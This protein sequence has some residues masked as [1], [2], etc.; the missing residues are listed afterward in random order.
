MKLTKNQ[1]GISHILLVLLLVVV[2]GGVG[3]TAY[4]VGT[5]KKTPT[6][7]SAATENT[8]KEETKT[9]EA[10]IPEGFVE[11]ENK[12]LGFKF[13]YPKEWGTASQGVSFEG[14]HAKTGS[15][16]LIKFD[17]NEKVTA[18]VRSKDYEHDPEM[19]HGGSYTSATGV[20][21]Y[22]QFSPSETA[23]SYPYEVFKNDDTS[24]IV[25]GITC[26]D[27]SGCGAAAELITIHKLEKNQKYSALTFLFLDILVPDPV[28]MDFEKRKTIKWQPYISQDLIEQFKKVEKTIADL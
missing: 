7:S 26:T 9:E 13:A 20:K 4:K 2:I 24:F 16:Y 1:S 6:N 14:S 23:T 8:K 19:G 17:K 28:D 21:K 22:E 5:S 3:F 11:Y 15:E 12:E 18:A 27:H 25:A 10:K